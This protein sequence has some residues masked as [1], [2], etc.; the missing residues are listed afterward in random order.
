MDHMWQLMEHR[1]DGLDQW[2][3]NVHLLPQLMPCSFSVR[4]VSQHNKPSQQQHQ[5]RSVWPWVDKLHQDVVSNL[6][7]DTPIEVC[8]IFTDKKLNWLYFHFFCSYI[9]KTAET[10]FWRWDLL[11]KP[12]QC[13]WGYLIVKNV[14]LGPIHVKYVAN[15]MIKTILLGLQRSVWFKF[16]QSSV[17]NSLGSV[18][19]SVL[20][21]G[22][23]WLKVPGSVTGSGQGSYCS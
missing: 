2:D 4:G 1:W 12:S 9:S 11:E 5:R 21:F 6:F 20:P 16:L 8:Y 7:F 23:A 17:K 18:V 15:V 3:A 14:Y 13:W 19:S 10:E 22:W